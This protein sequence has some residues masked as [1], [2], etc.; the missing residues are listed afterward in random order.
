MNS[1]EDSPASFQVLLACRAS[2]D[3]LVLAQ[4]S[5]VT[6]KRLLTSSRPH[7]VFGTKPKPSRQMLGL[8][9]SSFRM[10]HE[11][12]CLQTITCTFEIQSS[13]SSN[14]RWPLYFGVLLFINIVEIFQNNV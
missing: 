9:Q 8:I 3:C 2:S 6:G 4:Q 13:I 5:K 10:R 12:K 14:R 1:L 7:K 11:V